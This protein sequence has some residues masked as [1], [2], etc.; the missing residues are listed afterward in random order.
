MMI[1]VTIDV[2]DFSLARQKIEKPMNQS[3]VRPEA[4]S[5]SRVKIKRL[6][7]ITVGPAEHSPR[8]PFST[9]PEIPPTVIRFRYGGGKPPATNGSRQE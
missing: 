8:R 4:I 3:E 2:R 1:I 9:G 7:R 5:L 6:D